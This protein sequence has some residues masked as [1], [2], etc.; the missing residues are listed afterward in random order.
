MNKINLFSLLVIF[1][2]LANLAFSM[3]QHR[4]ERSPETVEAYKLRMA[5]RSMRAIG[6]TTTCISKYHFSRFIRSKF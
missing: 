2:V 5:T 4:V 1:G 3:P 6:I